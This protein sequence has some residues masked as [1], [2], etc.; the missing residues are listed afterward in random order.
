MSSFLPLHD[1]LGNSYSVSMHSQIIASLFDFKG[2]V[3]STNQGTPEK[4]GLKTQVLQLLCNLKP[5][6]TQAWGV[7][8][9]HG[10]QTGVKTAFP[11]IF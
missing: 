5:V 2:P 8:E 6:L 11:L 4:P 1:K 7:W 9:A 10:R 3:Q